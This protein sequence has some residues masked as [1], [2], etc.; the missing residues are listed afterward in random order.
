MAKINTD[1]ITGYADMTTEQKIAALEAY[2]FQTDYTG[3]VKKE[4]YDRTASDLAARKAAARANMTA[5]EQEMASMRDQMDAMS[6]TLNGYKREK[7][8]ASL[9]AKYTALGYGDLSESTAIAHL[10]GDND[11]LFKNQQ[12]IFDRSTADLAAKVEKMKEVMS[13]NAQ[14]Q[15]P[16][17]QP[18]PD[19]FSDAL[20]GSP[21]LT[22][23][24]LAARRQ[25]QPETAFASGFNNYHSPSSHSPSPGTKEFEAGF[26]TAFDSYRKY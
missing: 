18:E 24:R 1:S 7:D 20:S 5:A 16:E 3:Y 22:N 15:E 10:D 23:A 26:L 6:Q 2:E 25:Q 4:I 13:G 11:T 21:I 17:P 9:T 19:Y 14:Q 12:A 8:I